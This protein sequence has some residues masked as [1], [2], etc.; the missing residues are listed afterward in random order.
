MLRSLL[1]AALASV[2]AARFSGDLTIRMNPDGSCYSFTVQPRDTAFPDMSCTSHFGYCEPNGPGK[3]VTMKT[4]CRTNGLHDDSTI[5]VQP[6][7][8]LQFCRSGFC[9][10]MKVQY[11]GTVDEGSG[12]SAVN[13][14]FNDDHAWG[15]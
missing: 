4:T 11:L 9:T 15:C 3:I 2:A 6:D 13:F 8:Q 7:D 14:R 12:H 10:C 1:V 5:H